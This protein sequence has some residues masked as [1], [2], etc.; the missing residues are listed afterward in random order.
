MS[1]VELLAISERAANVAIVMGK[2]IAPMSLFP[3]TANAILYSDQLARRL[4]N[5]KNILAVYHI[6]RLKG[7]VQQT[8]RQ[9]I[10][11]D[12][13][14]LDTANN[15]SCS[16]ALN[17]MEPEEIVERTVKAGKELLLQGISLFA[18]VGD[19]VNEAFLLSNI[20]Q[21]YRLQLH[22][23]MYFTDF[24]LPYNPEKEKSYV[25]EINSFLFLLFIVN[26][27]NHCLYYFN[28]QAIEHYQ[29]ALTTITD[30]RST[31]FPLFESISKDLAGIYLT[32]AVRLQDNVQPGM[33]ESHPEKMTV[34]I[35]EFLARAQSAYILIRDS[36]KCSPKMH[37]IADRCI[38]EIMFR[39]GKLF[40]RAMVTVQIFEV[41]LWIS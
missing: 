13:D 24:N 35:H 31:Q 20:G 3:P 18:L 39:F 26:L 12:V 16:S 2:K 33:I 15:T 28:L 8:M 14:A 4:G 17:A 30:F 1:F 11:M 37:S 21:L 9:Y 25:L 38:I 27:F 36:V 41:V 23:Q 6:E 29:R 22:C 7:F 32:Y 5:L 10:A 40:Q 34:E 19:R